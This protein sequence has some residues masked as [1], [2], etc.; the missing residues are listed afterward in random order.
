MPFSFPTQR[1]S[2]ALSLFEVDISRQIM[3]LLDGLSLPSK[4]DVKLFVTSQSV[5]DK[6]PFHIVKSAYGRFTAVCPLKS[7]SFKISF[8]QR[9]DGMFHASEIRPHTCRPSRPT[10]KMI[11]VVSKTRELLRE[12]PAITASQISS[13]LKSDH[14]VNVD[15]MMLNRAIREAKL[16]SKMTFSFGCLRSFLESLTSLNP[17]TTTRIATKDGVF[18]RA[19]VD[20]GMCVDS[21]R[22]TTGVV[23]LDACHI[24]A[25]YGGV[26]L[27][28]TVL[29][30]N[31]QVF[32]ASIGI[33]ESENTETWFWFLSLVT[34][35]FHIEH[36]GNRLVF[37]SDREK[38][39]DAAVSALFP[40]AAHSF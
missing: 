15:L 11:W 40:N 3:E 27:V 28:M 33:A 30:G 22:H 24:K 12:T 7:C 35:A 31:G 19:F 6:K 13:R 5:R 8:Y 36:G 39:I 4:A 16:C 9:L 25:S 20:L 2:G 34:F 21:F 17:G 10:I 18:E 26:L 29:D 37:L 38:G 1:V 32:P 14:G 23:G